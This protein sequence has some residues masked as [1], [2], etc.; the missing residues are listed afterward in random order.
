MSNV[1][2]INNGNTNT[3]FSARPSR[4]QLTDFCSISTLKLADCLS[5]KEI[6]DHYSFTQVVAA[7]V[8]PEFRTLLSEVTD[9]EVVFVDHAHAEVFVDFSET[10]TSTLG[11][12]RIC[13]A[14]AAVHICD[15]AVIVLDCGTAITTEVIDTDGVFRGGAILPGRSLQRRVLKEATGQLPLTELKERCPV[16]IGA[17]T[18]DCIAAGVDLGLVGAVEKL[19]VESCAQLETD[20]VTV[21]AAGGDAK[22]FVDSISGLTSV[23]EHFTM[24]GVSAIASEVLDLTD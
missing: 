1:L 15:P 3:Q 4:D 23:P 21:L 18:E 9:A 24:I 12:D 2:L 7:C 10:D 14:V 5:L 17:N 22:F 16:A 8:V 20:E 6:L 11:A 19:L 13:N